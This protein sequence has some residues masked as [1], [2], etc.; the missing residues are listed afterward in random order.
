MD[1]SNIPTGLKITSQIPLDDKRFALNENE[2]S[3]LGINNNL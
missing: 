2:L 1:Y 3:Y